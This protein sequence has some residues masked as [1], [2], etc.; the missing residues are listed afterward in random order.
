[1]NLT[2]ET[3]KVVSGSEEQTPEEPVEAISTIEH[4]EGIFFGE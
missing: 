1:M 2:A 3:T 4:T